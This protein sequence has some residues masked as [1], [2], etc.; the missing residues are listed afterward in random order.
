MVGVQFFERWFAISPDGGSGL[1]ELAY[2]ATA[3]A[4]LAAVAARRPLASL[5]RRLFARS[6]ASKRRT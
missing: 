5:V 4:V 6:A 2:V 3:V 1:L